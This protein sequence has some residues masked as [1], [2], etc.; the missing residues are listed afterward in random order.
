M[1]AP[2]LALDRDKV[3]SIGRRRMHPPP[4]RLLPEQQP[5]RIVL[6]DEKE[7]CSRIEGGKAIAALKAHQNWTQ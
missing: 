6:G 5:P 3:K 7:G 1:T 2:V 4:L